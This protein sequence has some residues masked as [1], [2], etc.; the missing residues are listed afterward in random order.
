[1]ENTN[2]I[3]DGKKR[4]KANPF[5][6]TLVI[7]Q[8]IGLI[9]LGYLYYNQT[10]ET[11]T[12][13]IELNNTVSEKESISLELEDLY[14]QYDG[15]KT[16]NAELNEK[17]AQEQQKILE[18]ID[19]VKKVK[20]SNSYQISQYKKELNTLRD[21]MKSY[22]VQIDSLNTKNQILTAENIEVKSAYNE[23]KVNNDK[24]NQKNQN[25]SEMVNIA[26][27]IK[28]INIYATPMNK[29]SKDVD[30]AKKVEKI[31]VC[32][33]LSENRIV[34]PGNR[35][36]FIRIAKPDQTVITS[37]AENI[38][39]YEGSN[40]VYTE[41]RSVDYQNKSTDMCIYW[42]NDQELIPGTYLIDIFTDGKLIGETS[43]ELK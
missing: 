36:V 30:K 38:F 12:V 2:E 33:T 19:E 27:V 3:T 24:L 8:T 14:H 40:I 17:L 20:S 10:V 37:T 18:L 23:I 41:K 1:M 35:I 29:K 5:L 16:N 43:L 42:T 15:L 6:I 21:I 22:I 28:A 32:F 25:L 9:A 31:K 34:D 13:F 26:S 11:E 4:R 7:L 39:N